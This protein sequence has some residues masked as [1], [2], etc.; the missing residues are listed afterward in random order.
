MSKSTRLPAPPVAERR[1]H[2][3][4]HHGITIEDPYHWLK[5]ERYPMVEDPDVLA[6]LEAENT[7]FETA[8]APYRDLTD[9]IFEE[10]RQ[11]FGA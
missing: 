10:R 2:S 7:Y 8:M 1:A 11:V 6:Y 9:G 5:D 3:F 4:T